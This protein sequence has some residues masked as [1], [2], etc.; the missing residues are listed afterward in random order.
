MPNIGDPSTHGCPDCG[1]PMY[2]TEAAARNPDLLARPGR[3]VESTIARVDAYR[4]ANGHTSKECPLCGSY[5][6]ASWA[7]AGED[8]PHYHVICGACGNDAVSP[9]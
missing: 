4:C 2:W 1:Q 3:G 8:W 5:E 6:T 7:D 9:P